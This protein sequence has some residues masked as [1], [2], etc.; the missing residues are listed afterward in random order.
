MS[1]APEEL[2]VVLRKL[3][4]LLAPDVPLGYTDRVNFQ[5][6]EAILDVRVESSFALLAVGDDVDA[7]YSPTRRLAH[8]LS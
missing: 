8:C 1:F 3:L 6:T 4:Q 5:A 2:L 7:A